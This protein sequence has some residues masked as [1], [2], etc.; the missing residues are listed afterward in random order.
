MVFRRLH[1]QQT[2]IRDSSLTIRSILH[3]NRT[4]PLLISC[5]V[6]R[7][8]FVLRMLSSTLSFCVFVVWST[9]SSSPHG[10]PKLVLSAYALNFFGTDVVQGYGWVHLPTVPGR[11]VGRRNF[12]FDLF[13][14]TLHVRLI[15]FSR[16][17]AKPRFHF[18]LRLCISPLIPCLRGCISTCSLLS[19]DHSHRHVRYVRLYTPRSTSVCARLTA[20]MTGSHPEYFD[21]K[22]V[23]QGRGREGA[24]PDRCS[25]PRISQH[26]PFH[27]HSFAVPRHK[28]SSLLPELCA[29]P[30]SI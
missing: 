3:S 11:C 12:V 6:S 9:H 25:F 21:S 17:L 13:Q 5:L 23:A 1:D 22:F 27:V 16:N 7:S 28:D 8:K 29:I 19:R 4:H 24:C 18:S 30:N 14:S 20:W 2:P 10:W 15:A 26:S